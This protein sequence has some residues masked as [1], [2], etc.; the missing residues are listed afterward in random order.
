MIVSELRCSVQMDNEEIDSEGSDIEVREDV[1]YES[2]EDLE[3]AE[4]KKLRLARL[5]LE[6][7]GA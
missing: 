1:G 3:T 2:E 5:Y 7:G 6:V 4:E